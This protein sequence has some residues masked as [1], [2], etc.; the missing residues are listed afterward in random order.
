M[1]TMSTSSV[2]LKWWENPD[3]DCAFRCNHE[4][5]CAQLHSRSC[6]NRICD[7]LTSN[8]RNMRRAF[9]VVQKWRT[10]VRL[11]SKQMSEKTN[12]HP[13]V[14]FQSSP[15]WKLRTMAAS[16]PALTHNGVRLGLNQNGR[17]NTSG[18]LGLS[19]ESNISA[20]AAFT[21]GLRARFH[22]ETYWSPVYELLQCEL[23]AGLI[24]EC[25]RQLPQA[26]LP[27]KTSSIWDMSSKREPLN[28]GG[29]RWTWQRW[30][31][32]SVC[33]ASAPEC[34][35]SC[36]KDPPRHVQH[37]SQTRW[38]NTNAVLI[39]SGSQFFSTPSPRPATG[40]RVI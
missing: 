11:K 6:S 40:S 10:A 2:C 23:A 28:R 34:S 31:P 20:A 5:M 27:G 16:T 21:E 1:E 7:Q 24:E 32:A 18:L 39:C 38:C 12:V 35:D 33:S 19:F 8:Y 26:D 13:N 9:P 15:L 30:T 29:H 25:R 36:T 14:L 4:C 22:R 37:E 17:E 3:K